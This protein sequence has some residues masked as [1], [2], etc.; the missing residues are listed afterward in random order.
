MK[1]ESVYGSSLIA[2]TLAGMVTMVLHP[3]GSQLLADVQRVAPV[4][5]AVHALA[6]AGLAITFFGTI[7]L[8][9]RLSLDGEGA[10]AGLVAYGMAA[11]AVLIAAV[12]SGLLATGLA[13]HLAVASG[14]DRELTAALFNY[15]GQINQA[16]ARVYAIASSVAILLWSGAIISHGRLAR[17]SGILGVVVG[18][19]ALLAVTIGHMRLDVHGMGAVVLTQGAWMITMGVLLIRARPTAADV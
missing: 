4:A 9:R 5:V 16:F 18:V 3:T 8:T 13:S 11:V 1:V 2:G 12:A 7:G 10:I 15:T 19:L 14:T 6:L 17:G